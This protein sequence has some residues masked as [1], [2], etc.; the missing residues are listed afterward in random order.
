MSLQKKN[1]WITQTAQL[2]STHGAHVASIFLLL[3]YTFY[4]YLS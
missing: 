2:L 3:S 1:I 4:I